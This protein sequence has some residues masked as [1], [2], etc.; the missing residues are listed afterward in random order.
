MTDE[1]S[2]R[3][4]AYTSTLNVNQCALL[5]AQRVDDMKDKE[6]SSKQGR[7]VYKEDAN[8]NRIPQYQGQFGEI[9]NVSNSNSNSALQLMNLDDSRFKRGARRAWILSTVKQLTEIAKNASTTLKQEQFDN[10]QIGDGFFIGVADAHLVKGKEKHM[11]KLQVTETFEM[12]TYQSENPEDRCK[13]A[14]K[15]G[16]IIYG[17][18]NGT[19]AMIFSNVD[20]NVETHNTETGEVMKSFSHTLIP[21]MKEI[22]M[23][24]KADSTS[25]KEFDDILNTRL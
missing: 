15:D 21:E 5:A 9:M 25:E 16:P 18:N 1:L 23:T 10:L 4:R 22:D 12:D 7:K 14:G 17:D 11:L 8:G 6:E 19:K 24:V 13:R 2:N 20:V 3:I